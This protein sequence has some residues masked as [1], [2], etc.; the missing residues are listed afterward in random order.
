[1]T[2]PGDGTC[3]TPGCDGSGHVSGQWKTHY[4]L[5][6]CPRVKHLTTKVPNSKSKSTVH[7]PTSKTG[8]VSG[9]ETTVIGTRSTSRRGSV[10]EEK[11]EGNRLRVADKGIQ[12]VSPFSFPWPLGSGFPS[13]FLTELKNS[14]NHHNHAAVSSERQRIMRWDIDDVANHVRLIGCTDQAK[15]F[16]EQQ[17]DGEAFLLLNQSDIVNILKIKLGPALK[18]FNTIPKF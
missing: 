13:A 8:S 18:I 10:K 12:H 1:M 2:N 11:L 6:G 17:I 5:S 7:S 9:T 16:S 3:P 4:S 14:M 15:I